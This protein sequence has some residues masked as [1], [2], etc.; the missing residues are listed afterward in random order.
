MIDV[1]DFIVDKG[2]DPEKIRESQRRR[3][4]PVEVVEEVITLYHDH[5]KSTLR[6]NCCAAH[7]SLNTSNAAKYETSQINSQI[8]AT[9]KEI[10]LKKKVFV[11]H[12]APFR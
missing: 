9:Q 7:T 11:Y 4:S 12:T 1:L 2:G 8:N 3:G 5:R 10:G 6:A